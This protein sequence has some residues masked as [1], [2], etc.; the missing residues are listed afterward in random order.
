M[1]ERDSRKQAERERERGERGITRPP[2]GPREAKVRRGEGRRRQNVAMGK[3]RR[4]AGRGVLRGGN[5]AKE[6]DEILSW[7]SQ[8]CS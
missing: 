7:V 8:R 3:E 4:R 2:Y 6:R 1:S 5:R